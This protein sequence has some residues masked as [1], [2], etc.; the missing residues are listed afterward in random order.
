MN[1][2]SKLAPALRYIKTKKYLPQIIG[3][4]IG[5][6]LGFTYYYFIGCHSGTCPITSSPWNSIFAGSVIGLIISL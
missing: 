1:V 6:T 4:V 3:V 2:I 5:G